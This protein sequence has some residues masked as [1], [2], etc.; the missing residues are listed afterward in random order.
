MTKQIEP[1]VQRVIDEKKELDDKIAKLKKFLGSNKIGVIKLTPIHSGLLH[2][3]LD[4]ME[5]Y[6]EILALRI[7]EFEKES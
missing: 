4:A 6:S 2:N 5:R 3:Q 1:H 7:E